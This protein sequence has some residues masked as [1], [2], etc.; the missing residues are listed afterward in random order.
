MHRLHGGIAEP[1]V[2]VG[3]EVRDCALSVEAHVLSLPVEH[4]EPESDGVVVV[5]LRRLND[6]WW[7][8][9][10][11][12]LERNARV[13]GLMFLVALRAGPTGIHIP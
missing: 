7:G 9:D 12:R 13:V 10:H 11:D 5:R 1:V 8:E 2:L 4:V 6:R 3:V